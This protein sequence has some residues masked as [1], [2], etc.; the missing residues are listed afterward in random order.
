[1]NK[2]MTKYRN[3]LPQLENMPF[4]TDGGLETTLI[5]HEGLDLPYFAAFDLLKNKEGEARLRKYFIAYA[6]LAKRFRVGLILESPTWRASREWGDLLSY[7]PDALAD[8]NRN[9]I[10]LLERIREEYDTTRTPVVVSGCIGPKGDG[11]IPDQSMS[12]EEA[13]IYHQE[14]IDT[15]AGTTADMICALTINRP[16]EAIGITRAAHRAKMPVVISFTV[17]TDGK[18]PTGKSLGDAIKLVDE[19]T[20]SYPAYYMINCAHPNHFDQ[21]FHGNES[22]ATRIRGVRANASAMSHAELNTVSELDAGNPVE[23]GQQYMRLRTKLC[24][25]N[26]LGGC[27]GT[28]AR[29]V[30]QIALACLPLFDNAA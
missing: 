18:L 10:L 13:E 9:A 17:E 24:S 19:A 29:H 3:S 15:L 8:A 23:L 25:L 26:V 6:E 27:C 20:S 1:V 4:L 28:D 12:V 14:Q 5:F 11:Y 21:E 2:A 30:E 7:D 22:W 16:E